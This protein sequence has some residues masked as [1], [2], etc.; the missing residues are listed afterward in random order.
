MSEL[1]LAFIEK[2]LKTNKVTIAPQRDVETGT[3]VCT[4]SERQ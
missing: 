3:T 4:M 2:W 1:E